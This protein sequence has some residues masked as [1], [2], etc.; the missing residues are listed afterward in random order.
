MTAEGSSVIRSS[1]TH[2]RPARGTHPGVLL[3]VAAL[4]PASGVVA[5]AVGLDDEP[6]VLRAQVDLFVLL[7]R[8]DVVVALGGRQSRSSP[9]SDH[10]LL[11]PGPSIEDLGGQRGFEDGRPAMARVTLEHFQHTTVI[12]HVLDRCLVHP[13]PH[14][15]W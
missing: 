15:V 9:Q 6:Q 12:E 5:A 8:P 4:A 3:G 11:Q 13:A 2:D 10:R 1:G 14:C 7:P